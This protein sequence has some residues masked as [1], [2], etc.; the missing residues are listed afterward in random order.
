[1]PDRLLDRHRRV[2]RRVRVLED[3]LHAAPNRAELALGHARDLVALEL[4]APLGRRHEPEQGSPERRLPAP[5]FADEPQHLAPAE[6]ERDVVDCLDVSGLPPDEP[7]TEAPPERVVR[8]ETTDR[9]E[10]LAVN[11]V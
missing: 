5:R 4:D 9:D 6:V 1:M 2:E 10:D 7:L 8:L 11:G 3:D